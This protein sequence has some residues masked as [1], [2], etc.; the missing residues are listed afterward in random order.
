MYRV[1]HLENFFVCQ[2]HAN[3]KYDV[4]NF[5]QSTFIFFLKTFPLRLSFR[6]YLA[7][8]NRWTYFFQWR[9]IRI[10]LNRVQFH[11]T[12][13][14][15]HELEIF[16]HACI[17]VSARA[18]RHLSVTHSFARVIPCE[19]WDQSGKVSGEMNASSSDQ[20]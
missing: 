14:W 7:A 19:T 3:L 17:S 5:P 12:M 8:K 2:P 15:N 11:T 6:V 4:L 18:R 13:V 10:T 16:L 1:N 20:L 9:N